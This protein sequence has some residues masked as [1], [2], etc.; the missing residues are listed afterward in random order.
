MC[1][2]FSSV[3]GY[4]I[5]ERDIL[6]KIEYYTDKNGKK[7]AQDY[8]NALLAKGDKDSR[9]KANKILHYIDYLEAKGTYI[10]EP[11]VKHIEGDMWELR[12]AKDRIF[13][14]VYVDGVLVLLH[15][16][17]KK[18]QKTPEIELAQARAEYKDLVERGLN[19]DE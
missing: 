13:F 17:T 14:V 3:G 6:Y 10:G 7:P 15:A 16:F 2:D 4:A 9:I 1:I 19:K 5:K 11:F 18:T 8:I 12:P